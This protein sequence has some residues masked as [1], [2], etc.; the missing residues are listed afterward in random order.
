MNVTSSLKNDSPPVENHQT[1]PVQLEGLTVWPPLFLAPMAGLTHSALRT[2]LLSFGGV[3]LL[4]TEMLAAWRVPNE[5]AAVSPFLYRTSVEYP[6]SYQLLLNDPELVDPAVAALE[7]LDADAVDFNL[8]CPAPRVK[9][10]G[11]GCRLSS[12]PDIVREIIS[13]AR[14]LTQLPLSAKIRLGEELDEERLISFCLLLED[15]GVDLIT[16][17]ARLNRESFCRRPRWDWVG[18]VK[19]RLSIPVIA[20][21]GIDSIESAKRCLELSGADGLM[22]GRAAAVKPWLFAEIAE[23]VYG[24]E[25][26]YKQVCKPRAYHDFA[27]ALHSRFRPERRLG[28]LKEFTHYFAANYAFGHHLAGKVQASQSF[29]QAMEQAGAFFARSDSDA[30]IAARDE[31]GKKFMFLTSPGD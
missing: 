10:A 4:S 6:L 13:R 5:N 20:N 15:E 9:R 12:S 16:V 21:G 14:K 24:V 23:A 31:L 11:G 17:H 8:G 7:R 30:F 19:K 22:I 3:G 26:N 25:K 18:K 28:R 2:L 27:S 29:E 1:G